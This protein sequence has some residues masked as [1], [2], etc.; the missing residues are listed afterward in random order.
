MNDLTIDTFADDRETR[1]VNGS[2]F[3]YLVYK[4]INYPR[5]MSH[6]KDKFKDEKNWSLIVGH[7]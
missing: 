2:R 4:L 7:F 5:R 6:V 3:Y 1:E